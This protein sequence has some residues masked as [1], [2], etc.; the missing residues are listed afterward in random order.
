VICKPWDVV[1]VPFPFTDR[2]ASK[3]RP[4]LALSAEKFSADSG[5]TLLAMITS[6][7]NPPWPLDVLINH[8]AAGLH[9]ASKV[10]LKLFTLDNRLVLRRAGSLAEGDRKAVA[11]ALA[12]ALGT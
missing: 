6:A 5:H 3:R 7:D 2:Q 1:V 4:S 12:R 11:E 8:T 10:R 9:A